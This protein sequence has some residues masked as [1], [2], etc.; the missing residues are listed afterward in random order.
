MSAFHPVTKAALVFPF[1]ML[2]A[3]PQ[4]ASPQASAP[5]SEAY[6]KLDKSI[7]CR[8][9]TEGVFGDN[10]KFIQSTVKV[11]KLEC[12]PASDTG[13]GKEVAL[14]SESAASGFIETRD[15]GRM[16]LVGDEL[17]MRPS[18]QAK[19]KRFLAKR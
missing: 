16:K 2:L 3:Y 8:V 14:K 18:D 4:N 12:G 5:Q 11:K 9:G 6:K 13:P 1:V 10:N 17:F 7:E 15:Y 19:L